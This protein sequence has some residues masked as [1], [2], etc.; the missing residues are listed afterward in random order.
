MKNTIRNTIQN[1][2]ECRAPSTKKH[3]LGISHSSSG[4]N[5]PLKQNLIPPAVVL[6][7]KLA[8]RKMV[9]KKH[10]GQIG[11]GRSKFATPL[12]LVNSLEQNLL[13]NGN[14]GKSKAALKIGLR[15]PCNFGSLHRPKAVS[16]TK[17]RNDANA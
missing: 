6:Q 13:P 17:R 3:V 9:G 10:G 14:G 8:R 12:T 15:A 16:I 5:L 4:S 7:A 2:I 1:T 11:M